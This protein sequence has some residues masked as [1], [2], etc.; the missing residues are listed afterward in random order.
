LS[1]SVS[2]GSTM[3]SLIERNYSDYED[4]EV[5]ELNECPLCTEDFDVTDKN[6]KPCRCGYQICIWCWHK[7]META[8]GRCPNCRRI[9]DSN[10]LDFTPPDPTLIQTEKKKK[11]K[12]K[13]TFSRKQLVNVR[14]IQRNLVYVVGLTLDVAREDV[15]VSIVLLYRNANFHTVA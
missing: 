2:Y 13:H 14:V 5:E 8:G 6:F 9:Y 10:N 15:I 3:S 7:L 1:T 11:T 12:K 4:E